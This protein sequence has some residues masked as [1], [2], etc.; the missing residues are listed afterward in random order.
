MKKIYLAVLIL[1]S[2]IGIGYAQTKL[3]YVDT[4]RVIAQSNEAAEISRLFNLDIQNWKAQVKTMN[5]EIKRMERAFEIDKLTKNDA[6]KREAQ[7]RIDAKKAE[8]GK[9]IDEYFGEGG[10]QEQRYQEL[11]QPLTVKINGI[12][13]KIAEDEDY[14]MIFDV[15][16]GTVLYAKETLDLTDLVI[17]ELNKDTVAPA[18]Q[19]PAII[20]GQ[21][22]PPK[23]ETK[24]NDTVTEPKPDKP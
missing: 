24:P 6:A 21:T 5:E 8:A 12:I 2:V 11:L 15:S 7:A 22:E 16:L 14:T 9:F 20:P 18:D 23:N 4:D 17:Q 10:K 3:G 13:V 19:T 1:V